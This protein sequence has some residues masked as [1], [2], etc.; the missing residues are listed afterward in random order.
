M[1]GDSGDGQRGFESASS[2]SPGVLRGCAAG[3]LRRDENDAEDFILWCMPVRTFEH[4]PTRANLILGGGFVFIRG[5]LASFSRM[6]PNGENAP[7]RHMRAETRPSRRCIRPRIR[8]PTRVHAY[9]ERARTR[10]R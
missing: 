10:A 1:S 8:A 6:Q 7:V 4:D 9:S 2:A 5:A 3:R